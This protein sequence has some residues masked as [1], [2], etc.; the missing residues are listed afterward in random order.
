MVNYVRTHLS[1]IVPSA[2]GEFD[3]LGL[4]FHYDF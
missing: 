2:R 1:S 3:G 4:R